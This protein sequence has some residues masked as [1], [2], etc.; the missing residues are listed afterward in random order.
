MVAHPALLIAGSVI[1][2]AAVGFA[3][4]EFV[5]QPW[6]EEHAF[7]SNSGSSSSFGDRHRQAGQ[8]AGENLRELWN[9]IASSNDQDDVADDSPEGRRKRRLFKKRHGDALAEEVA[10]RELDA[11]ADEKAHTTGVSS[12]VEKT[13]LRQRKGRTASGSTLPGPSDEKRPIQVDDVEL[14]VG[15]PHGDCPPLAC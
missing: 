1:T 13:G 6:R 15:Y 11:A 4:N 3:L 8:R 9:R 7:H 2:V 5:I 12:A 14:E 10:A